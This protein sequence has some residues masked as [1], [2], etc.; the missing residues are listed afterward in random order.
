MKIQLAEPIKTYFEI[1]NGADTT[2]VTCCFT[3]SST[4]KDEGNA[5]LGLAAIE[6]WIINARKAF[7]FT[8][9]PISSHKQGDQDIVLAEVSGNFPGSPVQLNYAFIVNNGK[10]DALAIFK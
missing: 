8:S 9:T 2:Q 4:V 1:N 7:Q 5:Y 10:I 6:A 3:E